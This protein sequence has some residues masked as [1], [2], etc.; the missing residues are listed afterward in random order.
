MRNACTY[1]EGHSRISEGYFSHDDLH[2]PGPV[3][4]GLVLETSWDE[5]L[6]AAV[7]VGRRNR[8]YVF[9]HGQASKYEALFRWSLTR[10]AVEQSGPGG[11]RLRPTDAAKNPGSF[12]RLA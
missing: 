8:Q 11:Y 7:T 10:M 6:W 1:L 3:T 9:K 2:K 4:K 5:V 12:R